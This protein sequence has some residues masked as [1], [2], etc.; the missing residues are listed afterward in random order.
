MKKLF[1]T[2]LLLGALTIAIAQ[3]ISYDAIFTWTPN[4]TSELVSGY[5]IEYQKLPAVTNWTYITFI[6]SNTNTATIKNLQPG[7]IYKFRA[8]AVNGVGT[9]T[10]LS[11]IIQ[12]PANL[13]SGVTNF[14]PSN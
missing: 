10:N 2:I 14:N 7:Y 9:G 5:R 12:I 11:N 8:F 6:P 1:A 3:S 4:P 13:P